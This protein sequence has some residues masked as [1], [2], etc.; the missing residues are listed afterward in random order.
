MDRNMERLRNS[1]RDVPIVRMGDYNYFVHPL[2]D[3]V[4]LLRPELI[5]DASRC[6][7]E[8]LPESSGYDI[9]LTVESMG[10]PITTAVSLRVSKPYSIVRKR[11]YGLP[12][13]V[14]IGQRTGY[15]SSDLHLDLPPGGGRAVM[16]DDVLSTG[17][18]LMAVADGIR[19]TG[20]ELVC[21]VILFNKM[22][23]GRDE[24]SGGVGAPIRTVLDVNYM[25]G[26]FQ[27]S[28]SDNGPV[29]GG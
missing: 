13:E 21:A 2:S 29:T 10:I 22:G 8:L 7:I 9:L 3:G 18:T 11:R 12:G 28:P 23:Q 4:P 16:L 14:V 5:E 26:S 1:F 25:D 6:M 24:L 27:V 15:S 19:R 17:G 20:W